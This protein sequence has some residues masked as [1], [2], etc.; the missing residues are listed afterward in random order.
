MARKN[1]IVWSALVALFAWNAIP[2]SAGILRS[3][4]APQRPVVRVVLAPQSS[5]KP[6]E[7][8]RVVQIDG[9]STWDLGNNMGQWPTTR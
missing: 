4:P 5:E 8:V 9:R 2:S 6:G 7:S 1:L 3:R